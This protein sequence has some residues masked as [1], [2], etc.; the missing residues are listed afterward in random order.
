MNLRGN[1]KIRRAARRGLLALS[2]AWA[3][4]SLV[5]VAHAEPPMAPTPIAA[6]ANTQTAELV[7]LHATNGPA[8]H[9]DPRIG[10]LPQL[11]KPPFSSYNV[12]KL[13]DRALLAVTRGKPASYTLPNGR[14]L[15]LAVEPEGELYRVT[16]SISQKKGNAYLKLLEVTAPKN[17]PFFVAGQSYDKGSLVL[18]ITI[19]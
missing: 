6:D 1:L 14:T 10:T 9:I 3:S 16:A 12:Y 18:A 4:T 13:L 5:A 17:E 8:P 15:Q 11:T 19:K 2:L 7:V